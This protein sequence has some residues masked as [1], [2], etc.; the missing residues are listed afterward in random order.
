M[1]VAGACSAPPV[2]VRGVTAPLGGPCMLPGASSYVWQ[3][4]HSPACVRSGRQRQQ[5][6]GAGQETGRR[7]ATRGNEVTTHGGILAAAHYGS[8]LAARRR[9]WGQG[10]RLQQTL[11]HHYHNRRASYV[12]QPSRGAGGPRHGCPDLQVKPDMRVR[13]WPA[14]PDED[15]RLVGQPR[16]VPTLARALSAAVH[17]VCF[18]RPVSML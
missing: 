16:S 14:Q 1:M 8:N 18:I 15:V 17:L 9:G 2:V 10:P 3:R 6:R 12:D 11:H 13:R 7:S 5:A 4:G